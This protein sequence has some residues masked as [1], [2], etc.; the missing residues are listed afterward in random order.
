MLLIN[1]HRFNSTR[2]E[3]LNGVGSHDWFTGSMVNES[4]LCN[5]RKRKLAYPGEEQGN[6]CLNLILVSCKTNHYAVAQI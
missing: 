1:V 6:D 5:N 4:F 2:E 3:D